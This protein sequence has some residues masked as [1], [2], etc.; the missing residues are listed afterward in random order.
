MLP[1][2]DTYGLKKRFNFI[3]N[4]IDKIK[5]NT[6]L[7]YGCGAGTYL[8]VP[9]A[10]KY[11][12]I[13]FIGADLDS[14]SIQFANKNNTH[15]KNLEFIT[16]DNL[17]SYNDIKLIIASE[18]LEH[19]DDPVIFMRMLKSMLAE[20]G[21]LILTVPN[22][23]GPFEWASFLESI[24][25]LSGI[26]KIITYPKRNKS[27]QTITSELHDTL[28]VSPH[29]NF[30]SYKEIHKLFCGVGM[31]VELFLPRTFLCGY[32]FDKFIKSDTLLKWNE[33]FSEKISP[34]LV[35]DWMFQL[36]Q[37]EQKTEY[38]Y[39]KTLYGNI[40]TALNLKRALL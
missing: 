40:R 5:P 18:V 1:E 32:G 23:Y 38:K 16:V 33:S 26:G 10:E 24:L 35:S 2:Y 30:F 9:L 12:D 29:I 22:G 39:S 19:V 28:A 20:N 6:I 11:S 31:N 13:N 3:C 4:C 37:K 36:T 34:L 15:L 21:S 27:T 7:D 8:T 17:A 25:F 14:N